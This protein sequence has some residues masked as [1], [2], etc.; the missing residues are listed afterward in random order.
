[1]ARRSHRVALEAGNMATKIT[2]NIIE[3]YLNCKYKGHLKLAGGNG[4]PSDYEVM[5]TASRTTLRE[6]ALA[7]LVARIG[8]GDSYRGIVVTAALLKQRAPIL[9][10]ANLEDE[11]LSLRFDALKRVD[12]ASIASSYHYIPILQSYGDKAGQREKLLVA[13]FGLALT[14]IQK[15]RPATGLV[16]CG[17]EAR[18]KKVRLESKLYRQAEKVLEELLRLQGK[19]P[20]QGRLARPGMIEAFSSTRKPNRCPAPPVVSRSPSRFGATSLTVG[21]PPVNQSPP[22]APPSV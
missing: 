11:N 6:E 7:R 22:S 10:D 17:P 1:M 20:V 14:R 15:F 19:R 5:S 3:S 8:E 4:T 12:G 13:V 16:A 2:R 21:R 18:L 9:L